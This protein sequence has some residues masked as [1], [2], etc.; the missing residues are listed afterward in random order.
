[1]STA[2]ADALM[3]SMT[4]SSVPCVLMVPVVT[5]LSFQSGQKK[6]PHVAGRWGFEQVHGVI[7]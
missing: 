2:A 6:G 7:C 4:K 3:V 1:L 5:M